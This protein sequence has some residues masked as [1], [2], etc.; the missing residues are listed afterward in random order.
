MYYPEKTPT[1]KTEEIRSQ[2][3]E[4]LNKYIFDKSLWDKAPENP[5]IIS[6]LKVNS[7]RV[8]DIVLDIEEKYG[9]EIDDASIEKIITVEDAVSIIT[10]KLAK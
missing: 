8:V 10:G 1:M 3:V 9:I 6:D 5:K 2:V 7:A 4:I